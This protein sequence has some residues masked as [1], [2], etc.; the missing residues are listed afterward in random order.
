MDILGRL[1]T[2]LA[3]ERVL[4]LLRPLATMGPAEYGGMPMVHRGMHP[5][6]AASM[7]SLHSFFPQS[8]LPDT[9]MSEDD[10]SLYM[11][12]V[13]YSDALDALPADLTRSFSDLREL[14]AVLGGTCFFLTQPTCN[15]SPD[16]CM[17][18]QRCWRMCMRRRA[19]A[20]LRC[21]KS[22]PRRVRTKW[23]GRT[24]SVSR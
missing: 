21:R 23:E 9:P 24:R 16:A 20:C 22:P 19:S 10:A 12:L 5:G 15:R 7:A 3:A 13:T 14:D 17:A 18:W 2:W 11:L 8:R 6:M 4:H 1:R